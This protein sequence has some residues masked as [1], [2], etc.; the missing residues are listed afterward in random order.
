MG[1]RKLPKKGRPPGLFLYCNG[2]R[3]LY[4]NDSVVKCKCNK[5]VYKARV[6]V[7]GTK[8]AIKITVLKAIN[9]EDAFLEFR[10]FK[11]NLATNS[12]Q[13][14]EIIKE[15]TSPVLL[16][17]CFAYYMGFL[18]NIGVP[19][20]KRKTR[21]EKY[22]STFERN[23]KMYKE[24][25]VQSGI[26]FNILKFTDVTEDMVGEIHEYLLRGKNYANKSYNNTMAS[27]SGFTT[28]IIERFKLNYTN[29]FLDVD[30]LIVVSRNESVHE[31]EFEKLLAS[32]HPGNGIKI[33]KRVK[34][35]NCNQNVYRDW[36]KNGIILG[37]FTGGR[38]D[39]IVGLKWSQIL[40][41]EDGSFDRFKIIHYKIERANSHL[42]SEKDRIT[43]DVIITL[44]LGA[45]LMEIGYEKYKGTDDYILAPNAV[46]RAQVGRDLSSG[47]NH[48]YGLLGTGK[49]LTFKNLRKTYIT[50]AVNQFGAGAIA[51]SAHTGMGIIKDHYYD[52]EIV[53]NKAQKSFSVFKKPIEEE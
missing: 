9:F 36:L 45:F 47:F 48:Y 43:K 3:K 10:E 20:F 12:Y 7:P 8:K 31:S 11:K 16:V 52:K 53:K 25:L 38:S 26:D 32:I 14:V 19:K 28:H 51:L 24:A 37:L 22:I 23:F 21:S 17:D 50:S 33:K 13:K 30:K 27:Y 1:T 29:P 49:N 5:L 6:H 18:N 41:K 46:N 4:A 39:E 42:V 40:L 44:E 35:N 15:R 34:R 2:C